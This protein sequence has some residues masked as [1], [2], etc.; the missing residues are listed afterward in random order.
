MKYLYHYYAIY[1]N[2]SSIAH[3]DGTCLKSKIIESHSDYKAFKDGL[4]K[5]SNVS[6][7]KITICSLNL[8]YKLE[9]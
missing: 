5:D 1:H 4:A 9:Q 3:I 7:E 8:L 6:A 2:G